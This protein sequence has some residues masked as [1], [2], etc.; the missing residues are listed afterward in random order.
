MT[1]EDAKALF[2][3]YDGS[4]FAMQREDPEAYS[5]FRELVSEDVLQ[6]WL[7]ELAEHH[8]EV[9]HTHGERWVHHRR[10]IGLMSQMNGDI[11]PYVDRL[12]ANMT[13]MP[14][15]PLEVI[16]FI[17]N[18]AGT[19][20]PQQDGGCYLIASRTHAVGR[21]KEIMSPY[22]RY[23]C[24]GEHAARL[25]EAKRLYLRAEYRFCDDAH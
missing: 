8:F 11:R 21:M 9:W 3:R 10:L 24:E 5:R 14:A 15:D 7:R 17:E 13:R 25:R 2:M 16:L 19:T 4:A 20:D 23:F 22:L 6:K 12:L 1:I 18:M